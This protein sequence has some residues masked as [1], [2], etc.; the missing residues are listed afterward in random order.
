MSNSSIN[1]ALCKSLHHLQQIKALQTENLKGFLSK[2]EQEKEGFVT[3]EYSLKLLEEM[4]H[5]NPAII[6][7][8]NG[9]LVG[10]ALVITRQFLGNHALLDDL[11]QNIDSLEYNGKKLQQVSYVVVGQLCVAKAVRGQGLGQGLY[12]HFKVCYGD[13]YLYCITDVDKNNPRSLKT[14]LAVGFNV[15]GNL[16]YGGAQWDI[17]LWD[18]NA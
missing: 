12:K 7:T 6:A 3:A 17:V 9:K 10:Y 8:Q 5:Q 13:S 11:I 18:W 15:I 1:Y 4:H 16:S 2:T 14:H